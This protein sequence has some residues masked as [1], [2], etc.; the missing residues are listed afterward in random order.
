MG[1]LLLGVDVGTASS[2]AVVTDLTGEVLSTAIIEHETSRPRPGWYEHDPIET[3]WG[4]TARLCREVITPSRFTTDDI[5]AVSVS[6]IGPCL[7]P[8]DKTGN[9]LRQ[10]ILYGVDTRAT[11]EI[12]RLTRDVEPDELLAT[13]GMEFT[14]QAIGPKIAWLH[15]Q[16]PDVWSQTNTLTSASSYIVYRLTGEHV[17]DRHTGAHFMP[18]MDVNTLSWT[19]RF[20]DSV[21]GYGMLPR[22]GW[23]TDV[24][25]TITKRAAAETGLCE[26]IPVA[27]G[28]VDAAA[29]GLSVGVSRPGD[30]M[31]MYGST[32][33]FILVTDGP[34][35][36]PGAWLVGGLEPNQYHVAA[37]LSTSGSLTEW[38][39]QLTRRETGR[40]EGYTDL[41]R[42]ASAVPAGSDGLLMLPYFAGER[43]PI[44]DPQATG[45]V[46]GLGLCHGAGHLMRAALEGV[47][48]GARQNI[49]AMRSA[50]ASIERAVA[51]GGGTKDELWMQIVT[52]VTG[53][54]Q[55]VPEQRIGAAFGDAFI[56]GVASGLLKMDD[57]SAWVKIEGTLYP[58]PGVSE[59]H[60]ANAVRF[61]NLYRS[62]RDMQHDMTAMRERN[63]ND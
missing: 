6:A 42:E 39:R 4:E 24:A 13:S 11:A 61:R 58:D 60:D 53:V 26:G 2:K 9:P 38:V 21:P 55:I 17:I 32:M 3:W 25:G 47:A 62:T 23:A 48:H 8:L 63:L 20:S 33:F 15:D 14:S 49:E 7:L 10:G 43:T 44:N 16:E 36:V 57:L 41:F 18:F 56:A 5:A 52:D 28:T 50:G 34:A 35:S 29:E 1:E 30:L 37:G 27:V 54:E 45:V 46:I 40:D 12:E 59:L 31:I 51:V 22:L 19:D